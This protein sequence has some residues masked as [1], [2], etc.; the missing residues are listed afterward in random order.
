MPLGNA[1]VRFATEAGIY[2]HRKEIRNH[3]QGR[4]TIPAIVKASDQS[5][6]LVHVMSESPKYIDLTRQRV[7]CRLQIEKASRRILFNGKKRSR[8]L[9]LGSA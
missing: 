8:S 6:L 7:K 1:Y 3:I 2:A 4:C 9:R 5:G